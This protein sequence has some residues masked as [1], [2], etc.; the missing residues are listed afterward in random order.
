MKVSKNLA[1]FH[2]NHVYDDDIEGFGGKFEKNKKKVNES[3]EIKREKNKTTTRFKP[4]DN[5]NLSYEEEYYFE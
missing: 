5:R 1:R 3:V 2:M 4:K